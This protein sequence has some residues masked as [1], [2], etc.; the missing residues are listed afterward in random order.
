MLTQRKNLFAAALHDE[1]QHDPSANSLSARQVRDDFIVGKPNS[2]AHSLIYCNCHTDNLRFE[3]RGGYCRPLH[4][5]LAGRRCAGRSRPAVI[6]L[7]RFRAD[8]PNGDHRLGHARERSDLVLHAG[9]VRRG[10]RVDNA[11]LA[12]LLFDRAHSAVRVLVHLENFLVGVSVRV[13]QLHFCLQFCD[14]RGLTGLIPADIVVV[15]VTRS[16]S[17]RS[18]RIRAESAENAA[19][20]AVQHAKTGA[21]RT[22]RHAKIA[23]A[24]ACVF[25]EKY[26]RRCSKLASSYRHSDGKRHHKK[27]SAGS[28]KAQK[29]ASADHSAP[30]S[31]KIVVQRL[32]MPFMPFTEKPYRS[33]SCSAVAPSQMFRRMIS[34]Y[35]AFRIHSDIKCS[36]S[37][38]GFVGRPRCIP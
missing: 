31:N 8:V 3:D 28:Y 21:D 13:A 11:L 6:P 35:W 32:M 29:E 10:L 4:L 9:Q 25:H 34:R 5:A 33:A 26:L 1:R 2:P 18:S 17:S 24:I 14:P 38:R 12:K 15:T 16:H 20:T 7:H 22:E 37:L 30:A 27:P 36:H 23:L 19:E